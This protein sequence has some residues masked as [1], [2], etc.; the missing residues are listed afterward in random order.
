MGEWINT[1][2]SIQTMEYYSVIKRNEL[3][4]FEKTQRNLKCILVSESSHSGKA[5]DCMSPTLGPFGKGTAV[6][7]VERSLV[8][9]GWERGLSRCRED[10]QSRVGCKW[11]P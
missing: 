6:E 3:S 8:V 11:W 5:T 1:L 7:T 4:S 10:F 2:S 9:R